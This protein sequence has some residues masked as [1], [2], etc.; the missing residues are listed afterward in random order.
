[1][2]FLCLVLAAQVQAEG[3]VKFGEAYVIYLPDDL[4]F[5]DVVRQLESEISGGNWQVVN[6]MDIGAAVLELGKNIESRV[7]SVCN[8]QYLAQAIEDD[9]FISLIIPCRFTVFRESI[10]ADEHSRIVVGFYDPV[11]E[12]N[13]LNLKHAQATK[14]ATKELKEILLKVADF[15]EN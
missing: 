3:I 14:I 11:A 4:D 6:Q 10:G 1:M 9:P 15:Y 8:I 13:A 7:L 2:L 5:D 12:A